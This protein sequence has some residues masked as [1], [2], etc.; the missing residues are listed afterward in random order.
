MPRRL[1]EQR[2]EPLLEIASYGRRGPASN[3]R[4]TP[5]EIECIARTVTRAPE[6]MVKVSGGAKS[7]R[8]ASRISATLIGRVGLR[9]KPTRAR[10]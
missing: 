2:G 4:L 9:S 7:V 1:F 5:T 10:D 3:L 6:V 8:G